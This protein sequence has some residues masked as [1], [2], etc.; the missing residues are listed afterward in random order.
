M[1]PAGALR[2]YSNAFTLDGF[3][4]TPT[5]GHIANTWANRVNGNGTD[6]YLH[7]SKYDVMSINLVGHGLFSFDSFDIANWHERQ[8]D[9]HIVTV[10]GSINGSQVV[11]QEFNF[12]INWKTVILSD[13]FRSVDKVT[14][15]NVEG[16]AGYDNFV[17]NTAIREVPEPSTLAIFA[18]GL[19]GLGVRRFKRQ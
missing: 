6:F 17:F 8:F 5:H 3:T 4:F 12:D 10:I 7:D 13:M 19:T 11:S 2:T 15:H 18:L 1:A 14:L 9:E 16:E